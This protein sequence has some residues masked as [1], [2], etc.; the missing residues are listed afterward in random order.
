MGLAMEVVSAF[1]TNPGATVST[2]TIATGDSFAIRNYGA[3]ANA[4]LLDV[5]GQ[6]AT[7]GLIRIRSPRLHDNVQGIRLENL[8]ATPQPLFADR[9]Y[10]QLYAQDTLTVEQ[11]GDAADTDC[12]TWLNYYTDL[13]GT[14][15][16]LYTWEEIRPRIVQVMGTEVDITTGGTK[17]QYGGAAAINSTFDQ[18]K[19]NQDYAV[20]GF[21]TDTAVSTVGIKSADFGNL[22]LG[23][24]GT[25][26]RIETRQ[27]WVNLDNAMPF[28]C[29]PV[30]NAA[31]KSNTVV[32]VTANVTGTAIVVT[33]FL[34]Q[35]S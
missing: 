25:T 33:F 8:G 31:N 32:D 19:A 29:V 26:Q 34:A 6:Q 12:V 28:P 15:A 7:K 16:R 17:G 23:G 27:W 1:V 18:F 24:P 3:A 10:T 11:S 21:L 13:P 4:Y 9:M 2:T 22:R 20:L 30:F 35:L 5:W 14:A